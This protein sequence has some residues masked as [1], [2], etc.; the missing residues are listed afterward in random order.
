MKQALVNMIVV[1][2][3]FRNVAFVVTLVKVQL[4]VTRA[5]R[6]KYLTEENFVS[7]G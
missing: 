7:R 6:T 5:K 1:Y 2:C 3:V 4:N